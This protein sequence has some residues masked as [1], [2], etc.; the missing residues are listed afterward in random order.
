MTTPR[1]VFVNRFFHPDHLATAQILADLTFALA[2]DGCNVEVV[3]SR[4]IYDDT[5]VQ[6]LRHE[7]GEGVAIRR[8]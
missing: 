7:T 3:T 2:R 8:V 5:A 6:L 1:V 4:G